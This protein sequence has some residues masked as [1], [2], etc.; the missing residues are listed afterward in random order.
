MIAVRI[1]LIH[2][3]LSM[4]LGASPAAG[5]DLLSYYTIAVEQDPQLR[6][7]QFK[8]QATKETLRQAWAKFLP[9]ITT[10]AEYTQNYQDVISTEN[11]V[12]K[13]GG[14]NY[15]SQQYSAQ[16]TQPLFHPE[17]FFTL[18]QAKVTV[19]KSDMELLLAGQDLLVRITELYFGVLMAQDTLKS[20]NAEESALEM[21]STLA[22]KKS[23]NGLI[24][25]TELLDAQA[26]LA[27]VKAD[28]IESERILDTSIQAF[29]EITGV[30]SSDIN[31]MKPDIPIM[32]PAPNDV[33]P[34]VETGRAKNLAL[35]IKRLEA[36]EYSKD[37]GRQKSGHYP[38]LDLVTR[39]NWNDTDGSLYGGGSVVNTFTI[40]GRVTIP[41]YS[42]GATNS[43]IRE[44]V[45]LYDKASQEVIRQERLA[46][47]QIRDF[48]H[49]MK[50]SASKVA[51]LAKSIEAQSLVLDAKEQGFASG[52]YNTVDVLD[53]VKDLFVYRKN[54]AKA[55]Y[56]YV[57]NSVRL[58]QSA[59]ILTADD[60]TTINSWLN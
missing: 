31:E 50:S 19:K 17:S 58:K 2:G 35:V 6:A 41:V 42:G 45:A 57:V 56:E 44:A 47:R 25:M 14:A 55:R 33:D 7:A 40:L 54:Y 59:G 9:T 23:N 29:M 37:I 27:A 5:K 52:L 32:N 38:T 39:W 53:A 16:L 30:P 8:H 60:I 24:P 49:G 21:H 1:V 46:I 12:Y 15:L 10:D 28:K 20:I 11:N 4:L 48:F 3:V 43:K 22:L 26:K 13:V 36:E 51:A 18:S 34:W